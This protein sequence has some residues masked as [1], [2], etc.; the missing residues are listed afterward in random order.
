MTEVIANASLALESTAQAP[1]E[2]FHEA[3]AG[4]SSTRT[5]ET[6]NG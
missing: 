6:E 2:A 3:G 1:G 5:K 4:R